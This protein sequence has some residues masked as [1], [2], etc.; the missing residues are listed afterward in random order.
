MAKRP[1][2]VDIDEEL[3]DL[4]TEPEGGR[5]DPIIKGLLVRLPAPGSSWPMAAR[6]AWLGLL[7]GSFGIIYRDE[8]PKPQ[9]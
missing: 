8:P 9:P 3:D 5:I 7:E 6:K 1:K 2:E 4:E